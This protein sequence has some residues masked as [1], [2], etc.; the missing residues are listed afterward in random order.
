MSIAKESGQRDRCDVEEIARHLG[1][2]EE[3]V[4]EDK[5]AMV[6]KVLIKW[7]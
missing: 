7:C 1:N 5:W 4:V 3:M 6:N 2:Y